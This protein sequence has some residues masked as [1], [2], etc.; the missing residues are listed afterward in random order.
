MCS[1]FHIHIVGAKS[2]ISP[3]KFFYKK[4]DIL[5][6]SVLSVT[7]KLFGK[8]VYGQLNCYLIYFGPITESVGLMMIL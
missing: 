2:I 6:L 4:L 8:L 7:A 3:V 1:I 5:P